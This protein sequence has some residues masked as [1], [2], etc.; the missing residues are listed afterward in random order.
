MSESSRPASHIHAFLD[1]NVVLPRLSRDKT[2]PRCLQRLHELGYGA[3]ALATEVFSPPKDGPH[4]LDGPLRCFTRLTLVCETEVDARGLASGASGAYEIL[5]ARPLSEEAFLHLCQRADVDVISLDLCHRVSFPLS[6]A[7]V[8]E[9]IQRGIFF[10]ICYAPALE[11]SEKRR[12]F[13]ANVAEVLRATRGRNLLFAGGTSDCWALRGPLDVVNLADVLGVPNPS[14][15]KLLCHNPHRVLLRAKSRRSH[16]QGVTISG[17]LKVPERLSPRTDE[18]GKRKAT[19][20]RS[21]PP[22]RGRKQKKKRREE[23]GGKEA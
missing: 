20:T 16:H 19:D 21:T 4:L 12:C 18:Q 6:P 11:N 8:A 5:A 3:C 13:I 23:G 14:A 7:A 15:K 1:L 9:A 2:G 22:K 17:P 10:E